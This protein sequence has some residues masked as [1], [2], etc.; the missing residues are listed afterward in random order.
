M[1]CIASPKS[2]PVSPTL[3]SPASVP[4]SVSRPS[5]SELSGSLRIAP[6]ARA[7][8]RPRRCAS[9]LVELTRV[10]HCLPSGSRRREV[11]LLDHGFLHRARLGE[12]RVLVGV[13]RRRVRPSCQSSFAFKET[14]AV[15]MRASVVCPRVR[16]LDFRDARGWFDLLEDVLRSDPARYPGLSSRAPVYCVRSI[17]IFSFFR[18]D[19]RKRPLALE[20]L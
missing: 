3:S 13:L 5:S 11:V 12:G 10:Y 8:R 17:S 15:P 9:V 1:A 7:A 4:V 16:G 6:R 2:L 18:D 14:R 20:G 19:F